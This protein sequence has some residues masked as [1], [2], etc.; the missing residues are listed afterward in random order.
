MKK[1]ILKTLPFILP[2]F[3]LYL[4]SFLFY[5]DK[6][7]PDLLRLGYIPNMDKGYMG[8]LDSNKKVKLESLSKTKSKEFKILTIGDSF[9]NRDSIGYNDILAENFS[10]LN[11]DNFKAENQIQAIF[12]LINGDFFSTY[13]IDYV[14]LQNIERNIIYNAESADLNRKMAISEIYALNKDNHLRHQNHDYELFSK[15]TLKFP[16]SL[17]KFF[18]NK[19]Y[20]SNNKVFN[21][22]LNDNNLFSN[23]SNKLLFLNRDLYS[24]ERNNSLNKVEKLNDRL[25]FLAKKLEQKNVKLIV[26]PAPD[27]YD[28]YYSYIADKTNFTKPIFFENLKKLKKDYIYIDSKELLS[29]NMESK[30]DMYYFADTHWS[31]V[32]AKLIADEIKER[33]K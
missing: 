13:K 8:I 5:S 33:I 25:N 20:L 11:A 23:N 12:K 18:I 30:K 32:A 22:E 19:N 9:S 21:L 16:F 10:V 4:I 1:F 26:L 24:L 6:E 17:L 15:T 28:M 14:I 31:P 27:K 7:N 3:I 29:K 2:F